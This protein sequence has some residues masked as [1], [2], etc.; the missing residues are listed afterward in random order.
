MGRWRRVPLIN[1]RLIQSIGG[2]IDGR[3]THLNRVGRWFG[4]QCGQE[5]QAQ[6]LHVQ[7]GI[8]SGGQRGMHLF[9]DLQRDEKQRM[10]DYCLSIFQ[11]SD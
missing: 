6:T 8:F 9:Q 3:V 4:A 10:V 7:Q 11:V 5:T 1:R 2:L